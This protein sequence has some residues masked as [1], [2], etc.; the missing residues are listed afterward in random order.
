VLFIKL[1]ELMQVRLR[2]LN[3]PLPLVRSA[4]TLLGQGARATQL[5]EP[6]LTDQSATRA[7]LG[8]TPPFTGDELLE[9]TV[10]WFLS[11]H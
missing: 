10:R 9:R 2:L 4:A 7:A 6:L 5:C 3:V 8:W 11:R 1:A